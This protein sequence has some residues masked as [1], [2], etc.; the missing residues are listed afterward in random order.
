MRRMVS[1]HW[2]RCSVLAGALG[3]TL[4]GCAPSVDARIRS[5]ILNPP[6]PFPSVGSPYVLITGVATGEIDPSD[7]LDAV[8]QD[9]RLAPLDPKNLVLYSTQIAIVTPVDLSAGNHTMLVNIVNRGNANVYDVGPDLFLLKQGFSVV[10][11]GWQADLLPV[12]GLFFTMSA[13]VAHH[14]NGGTITGAARSEFTLSV[15]ASTQNIVAGSSTD[16]AGYPTVSLDNRHDTITMRVH[17]DDPK[18]PILNTDWAYAD[19]STVPFPGVLDPQKVCLRNG[20]DTNHIYELVYTARDPI[21]MGLGLAAIRDVASFFRYADKDDLGNPNPLAGAVKYALLYGFSQGAAVLRSYL[22]LGFNE[23]EAHR[24]VFDGMQPER[25]TRRN[26]IN[27]RFSQ[28]GRLSGGTQHTE[29]QY[30]GSDSPNTYGDTLDL[31]A[32]I[33]GGL[34]DRCRRT[35]T[36]PKVVHTMGDNEYWESSGAGVTT[37]VFGREAGQPAQLTG[38]N[39]SIGGTHLSGKPSSK[40]GLAESRGRPPLRRAAEPDRL[41]GRLIS[42]SRT[43]CAS[44]NSPAPSMAASRQSHRYRP[45]PG[46]VNFCPIP[47]RI[48]TTSAPC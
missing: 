38:T 3:M 2:K 33:R 41:A 25:S 37:D 8:I 48:P 27:V 15:P 22:S 7:P 16:T 44:I 21:V 13:P 12:A 45:R 19:C 9:I 29:A 1:A 47:I 35:G 28:P 24:Q 10:F 43:T 30:P 39:R 5:I 14:R 40:P 26:P 4:L 18:L 6:T 23:D 17:Q 11:A 20:F 32:G 36:C 34:L 31:L 42:R 46:S